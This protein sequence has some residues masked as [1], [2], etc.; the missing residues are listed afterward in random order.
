MTSYTLDLAHVHHE[1]Y[2]LDYIGNLTL[3]LPKVMNKKIK[4][5]SKCLII[6]LLVLITITISEL[7]VK[8]YKVG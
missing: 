4:N 8:H 3:F 1:I 5:D 2:S 7:I 6:F